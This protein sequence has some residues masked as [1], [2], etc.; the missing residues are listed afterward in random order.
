[1][2]VLTIIICLVPLSWSMVREFRQFHHDQI[3]TELQAKA[4]LLQARVS[5][6]LQSGPD[7]IMTGSF[8]SLAEQT[9]MRI[10]IIQ[11]SGNV[12]FDTDEDKE[13]MSDHSTRPEIRQAL[14]GKIGTALR[15]SD[16]LHEDMIYVAIPCY[17]GPLI[18]GVLR[19]AM[20]VTRI[21]ALMAGIV[22]RI[23]LSGVLIAMLTLLLSL[24]I[25][26]RIT[27][28]LR[29]IQLQAHA[30]AQG[31]FK[32]TIPVP[33]TEEIAG[34]V[35]VLNDVAVQLESKFQ[36]IMQQRN[37]REAILAS[38]VEGL[39]AI[40]RDEHII[41]INNASARLLGIDAKKAQGKLVQEVIRHMDLLKF[42]QQALSAADPIEEQIILLTP[43]Q[44]YVQ[45][46]GTRI[47]DARNDLIG[48][49]VVLHDITRMKHLE[50][51]RSEFVANVSHELKTPLTSLQGFVETLQDG[52][53]D[54]PEE[55]RRFL[56]IMHGQVNRLSKIIEDILVLSSLEQGNENQNIQMV[57]TPVH[58][59]VQEAIQT[60]EIIAR[61]KNISLE[62]EADREAEVLNNPE[63]LGL[64]LINLLDNA[65][66]YS[67]EQ[68]TISI[69]VTRQD[70]N[71]II[72]V[73]DRGCGIAPE[74][75][76]R[77]FE[78]FYRV[79]RARSRKLGGSGL[80]LSIVKHIAALHQA[81]VTVEST[82]GQGSTFSLHFPPAADIS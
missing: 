17:D 30:F 77:V 58:S 44:K 81:Q 47:M 78:R 61:E 50:N 19:T 3:R 54:Q 21:D 80:G 13:V 37:E 45:A 12:I 48:A 64:A 69:T 56:S 7:E 33:D 39:L 16:T 68:S 70:D 59:V 29:D 27:K 32:G 55:A 36:T 42:I 71:T 46:H 38:M 74:H 6:F 73:K 14:A 63:L 9:K 72:A 43:R 5:E 23:L 79:D 11:P 51:I 49:V 76:E 53:I 1:M 75:Q 31:E 10:T 8:Q 52:A 26:R 22:R 65:I 34:V 60:C 41:S 25:S 2:S 28:P 24:F 40:D 57:M 82:P 4:V 18:T 62:L 15:R 66:K 67:P 20:P 35:R